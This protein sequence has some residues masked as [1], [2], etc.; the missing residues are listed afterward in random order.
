MRH[1]QT[2]FDQKS[3]IGPW[4][5]NSS[6]GTEES[7]DAGFYR[8]VHKA[9]LYIRV[10]QGLQMSRRGKASV[11]SPAFPAQAKSNDKK[12]GSH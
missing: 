6:L 7:R 2:C 3:G 8:A 12:T 1:I 5:K 10:L 11:S 9:L 4:R